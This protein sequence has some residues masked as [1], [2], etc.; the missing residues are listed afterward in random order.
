MTDI[1]ITD[2]G[3][4]ETVQ[5]WDKTVTRHDHSSWIEPLWAAVEEYENWN[6][7]APEAIDDLKTIMAWL[8]EDLE[9]LRQLTGNLNIGNS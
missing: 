9:L 1:N 8:E 7:E 2:L 3:P 6:S 4:K 5:D